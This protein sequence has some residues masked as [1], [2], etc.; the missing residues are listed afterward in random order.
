M[1]DQPP[2][3]RLSEISH[4]F[5]SSVRDRQTNGAPRPKRTPP[6]KRTDISIDLTPEEF[7]QAYGNAN[8][9]C[10]PERKVVPVSALIAA[11]LNGTQFDRV[12][13]YA[14]HL[15]GPSGPLWLIALVAEPPVR[16]AP[17]VG[18]HLALL[19]RPTHDKAQLVAAVQWGVV[20]E[21]LAA[22]KAAATAPAEVESASDLSDEEAED[23]AMSDA[24]VQSA[25]E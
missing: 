11:H 14:R 17:N 8:A 18:E 21:F 22:A 12:K 15:A 1:S 25:A 2:K 10:D 13:Q 23:M 19:Y 16:A 9:G 24:P 20:A 7:A 6:G 4:L 5:L 3:K